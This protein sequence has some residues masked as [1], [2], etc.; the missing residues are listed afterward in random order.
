VVI[1]AL[2]TLDPSRGRNFLRDWIE[3]LKLKDARKWMAAAKNLGNL[4]TDAAPAVAAMTE[5]LCDK[6]NSDDEASKSIVAALG[7]IGPSARAAAPTILKLIKADVG[8]LDYSFS[9][10][11][12]EALCRID[13]P[14]LDAFVS[15]LARIAGDRYEDGLIR[16]SAVQRLAALGP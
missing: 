13:K 11:A 16:Q 10:C 4:G 9:R 12:A 2:T 6:E 1:D 15:R 7:K 5:A 3:V 8:H 14:E